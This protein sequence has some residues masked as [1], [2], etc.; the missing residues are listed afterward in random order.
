MKSIKKQKWAACLAGAAALAL[1]TACGSRTASS[2]ADYIGIDAAKEAALAA[3][4]ADAGQVQFENAGL[5]SQN[6]TFFYQVIFTENGTTYEYDIDALTGVVIEETIRQG[7]GQTP[8]AAESSAETPAE[9]AAAETAAA[10]TAQTSSTETSAADS[11]A[12][13]TSRA[14]GAAIDSDYAF[15]AALSHAGLDASDAVFY[16]VEPDFDDGMEVYEVEF[17]TADGTEYDYTIRADDG[18]ILSFDQDAEASFPL[19]RGDSLI[20]ESQARQA[21]LDRVPGAQADDVRIRLKEDDGRMEYEG[22]L[23]YDGMFYEFTIDAYSGGLIE[24]EAEKASR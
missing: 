18:S 16:K 12:A 23:F 9:T 7:A 17:V 5:D 14:S 24:W 15:S 10:E 21:V 19:N 1:L 11:P 3:A 8:A 6:G 20:E 13:E 22:S 2:A 4:G